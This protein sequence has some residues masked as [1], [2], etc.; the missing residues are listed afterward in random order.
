[1]VECNALNALGLYK[2]NSVYENRVYLFSGDCAV[3][4]NSNLNFNLFHMLYLNK[5]ICCYCC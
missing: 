1:M 4:G 3:S 5:Y 2:Y